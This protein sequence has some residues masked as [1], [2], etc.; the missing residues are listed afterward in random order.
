MINLNELTQTHYVRSL[1]RVLALPAKTVVSEAKLRPDGIPRPGRIPAYPKESVLALEARVNTKMALAESS[2]SSLGERLTLAKD[3]KGWRNTDVARLMK[4]SRELV[5]RWKIG[6]NYPADMLKL[7]KLLDVPVLWLKYGG[8]EQLTANSHL[9]R[10]V[11]G[12]MI[13][14]REALFGKTQLLISDLPDEISESEVQQAIESAVHTNRDLSVL[15]RRAGG[16]WQCV[17]GDLRFA[18]WIK[19]QPLPALQ[20]RFWPNKVEEILTQEL[21]E[22]KTVHMAWTALKARCIE[23]GLPYPAKISLYK[24][25]E[26]RRQREEKLGINFNLD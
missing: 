11:G 26:T 2:E 4:V 15:A 9:G 8:E 17:E 3:L 12:E 25:Q 24:R 7:A 5:R 10:R 16:R 23:C 18:P 14:S 19:P 1:C 6:R 21:A 13:S 20:R 22:H